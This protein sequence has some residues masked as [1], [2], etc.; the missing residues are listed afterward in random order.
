MYYKMRRYTIAFC[1]LL[2]LSVFHFALA[3]PVPVGEIL[4]VR[5][6]ADVLKDGI[7]AWEKRMDSG[8]EDRNLWSNSDSGV[9]DAPGYNEEDMELDAPKEKSEDDDVVVNSDADDYDDYDTDDT[10]GY[11]GYN[12]DAEDEDEEDDVQS[13]DSSVENTTPGP[14]SK[15][16]ATLEL[17]TDLEEL[18][19]ELRLRPRNS[20]SG[21]VGTPK[22]ELQGAADTKAYV[23]DSS[24]PL[25]T[26]QVTNIL[27]LSSMVR[28]RATS[29]SSVIG[30][31]AVR[32]VHNLPVHRQNR[33]E[34][35][36]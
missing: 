24:L 34:M 2:I 7:A 22:R 32:S 15:R 12:A 27:T 19:D 35:D 5:F 26:T 9:S 18:S 13:E 4:E 23:S 8:D 31:G 25:Q 30:G 10:D 21:A 29:V 16:P 28:A 6:N 36:S 17:M 11:D 1:F 3:A 33:K 14:V 20:G